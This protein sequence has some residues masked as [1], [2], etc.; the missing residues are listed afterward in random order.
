MPYGPGYDPNYNPQSDPFRQQAIELQRRYT[1]GQG[2]APG[3]TTAGP[4]R[5]MTSALRMGLTPQ[6]VEQFIQQFTAGAGSPYAANMHGNM[7]RALGFY[8]MGMQPGRL[9]ANAQ[10]QWSQMYGPGGGPGRAA[11]AQMGQWTHT[12]PH[13]TYDGGTPR[14]IPTRDPRDPL[15]P[16]GAPA[17]FRRAVGKSGTSGYL[18]PRFTG[19]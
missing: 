15:P 12:P 7:G 2:V 3:L 5:D 19:A 6:Q 18:G 10:N 11:Q 1:G 8:G 16:S 17:G 13:T 14:E 9:S 4:L